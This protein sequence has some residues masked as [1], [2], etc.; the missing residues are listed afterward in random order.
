MSTRDTQR[1][2][3]QYVRSF[4]ETDEENVVQAV[5]NAQAE[6]WL[7]ERA[8]RIAVPEPAIERT[9][10]FRWWT[11]RKHVKRTPEG[12]FVVTE[13][14]PD[15]SWAGQY[16][17]IPCAVGHH[18]QEGRWLREN[19]FLDDYI[20]FWQR[21]GGRP[22]RAYSN[23]LESAVE[24]LAVLRG[25][26]TGLNQID[27]LAAN[28]TA[29]REER[30]GTHGLLWSNDNRD[31][32]EFSVTGPGL[33]PT[34]NCYHAS[35]CRAVSA[36]AKR[37]GQHDISEIFETFAG[38]MNE[39]IEQL[40]DEEKRFYI[41]MPQRGAAVE[42]YR[43][44]DRRAR[45]LFGYL[46]WMFGT[47]RKGRS[48]A[49]RQL[50]DPE[51]FRAAYGP[52]TAERRHPGFGL[53]YTG[54]D[55]NAWLRRRG[56]PECGKEGHECLWNGPSWPFA[57]S[58]MLTA[59]ANLL[60]GDEQQDDI[61]AADYVSLLSQYASAHK[62]FREDGSFVPW[63]DENYHPDTGDWIARTR[64]SNWNGQR[65]PADKGGYE[66][67]KDYN[68]STFCNLVLEGLFGIR[69]S[70]N[71]LRVTP[72]FPVEWPY[73]LL[74]DVR[75]QGRNLSVAYDREDGYRVTLDG[76]TVFAASAP[77]SFEIPW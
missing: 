55:L 44:E 30:L 68:H 53:F 40:W 52:T 73:A 20:R 15:V 23:W 5:S 28:L 70:W 8:P 4:N 10:Y 74:E 38:Q 6:E 33:R 51:G 19:A 35:G 24:D 22:L 76:R 17:T 63:I 34:L 32:S 67:G 61:N 13:F 18:V 48:D 75:V 11:Y 29:W 45:E 50:L 9:Y 47:A 65:F 21:D 71:A 54:D 26:E 56:E 3:Q 14:H 42:P 57:T 77:E 2:L 12:G 72:L 36:M 49:F 43:S 31:G 60:A 69:P 46:P 59:L 1:L 25:D 7:L 64:L 27:S 66:R 16:N 62:L 41:P 39:A 37:A 58:L